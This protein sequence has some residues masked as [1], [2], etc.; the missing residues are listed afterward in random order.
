MKKL[1]LLLA[2]TS[3]AFVA[4][5]KDDD[6]S[7]APTSGGGSGSSSGLTVEKKNRAAVVYFG[8]DWCPP[9]GSY[10]GPTM[11]SCM[12]QEGTLLT[13]MKVNT[14]SNNTSLNW[15]TGNGMWNV[16]NSGVFAN[17][18]AI[19]SMAVNLTKQPISSSIASNYNGVKAK[20]NAFAADSV[21][22][23]IA[24]SKSIEG[25]SMVVKT[26]V[27]FFKDIATGSDYRLALYVVE[28]DVVASQSTSTGPM[29]PM[30]TITW[31]APQMQVHTPELRSILLPLS[32]IIRSLMVLLR[33]S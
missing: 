20:A 25:D 30:F 17:A 23:G 14:A 12:K 31:C 9:C 1:L 21:I 18:N 33:C 19:P 16:Y 29:H 5:K 4:C 7:P 8:E 22:A 15:S 2:V 13:A 32:P 24:L 26:K 10:G 28:N 27:K 3:I 6:E 11:D